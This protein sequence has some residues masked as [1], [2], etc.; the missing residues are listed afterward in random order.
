[1]FFLRYYFFFVARNVCIGIVLWVSKNPFEA[2]VF[3]RGTFWVIDWI[4]L[5]IGVIWATVK[6]ASDTSQRCGLTDYDIDTY[7]DVLLAQLIF[8]YLYLVRIYIF[9]CFGCFLGAVKCFIR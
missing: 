6:Y 4:A 7:R 9:M 1:M 3:M 5:T 8:G 2:N